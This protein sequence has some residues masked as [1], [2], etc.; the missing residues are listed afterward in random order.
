MEYEI[1]NGMTIIHTGDSKG[2]KKN[3]NGYTGIHFD[4]R[5][6]KHRAEMNYQ[7]K[8]YHL[9]YSTDIESLIEIRKEA[10]FH[11]KHGDFIDWYNLRKGKWNDKRS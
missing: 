6:G 1:T 8:K 7:R 2:G 5:S 9:G 3:K 11:V 4:K 10:E